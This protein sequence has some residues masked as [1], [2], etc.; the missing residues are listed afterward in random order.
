MSLEHSKALG[1]NWETKKL[2][3]QWYAGIFPWEGWNSAV[4]NP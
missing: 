4:S 1:R 3:L 2:L